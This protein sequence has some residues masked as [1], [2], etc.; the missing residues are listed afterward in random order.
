MHQFSYILKSKKV[1]NP[2]VLRVLSL[3]DAYPYRLLDT[4]MQS[5]GDLHDRLS[6]EFVDDCGSRTRAI[7]MTMNELRSLI[8][9][10][11]SFP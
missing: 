5:L 8:N 1:I 9:S 2:E 11:E 3:I 6:V 10:L 7:Y 4:D